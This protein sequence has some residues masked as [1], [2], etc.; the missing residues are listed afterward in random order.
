MKT[1]I[2]YLLKMLV[3]CPEKLKINESI[4][5]NNITKLVIIPD[6]NDIGKIIGKQGRII[7]AIRTIVNAATMKCNNKIIIEIAESENNTL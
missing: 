1:L 4:S 5:D 3:D 7:K 6:P 2:E